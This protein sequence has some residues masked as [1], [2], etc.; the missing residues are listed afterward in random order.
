MRAHLAEIAVRTLKPGT[1]QYKVFDLSTPGFG[2]L[3]G[4]RSKS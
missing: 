1:K 4:G 3:A 2:V